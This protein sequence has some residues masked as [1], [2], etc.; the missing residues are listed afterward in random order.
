M[1]HAIEA[2]YDQVY[3]LPPCLEDWVGPEHAARFIRAFVAQAFANGLRLDWGSGTLQGKARYSER[4]L[5][6]IWLYGYFQ[7][8]R[9][10]RRLEAACKNDLGMIWLCGNHA[11]DHNTLWRFFKRNGKRIGEVYKHTVRIAAKAEL[12]GFVLHALDGTKVQA[13]V[14]N[15]SGLHRAALEKGIAELDAVIASLRASIEASQASNADSPSTDL[16]E[17]LR[18]K[19]RLQESVQLAFDELLASGTDHLNPHDPDARVMQCKDRNRNVFAYNNQAVVDEQSGLIV[20]QRTTQEPT[21]S[22][23][24]ATMVQQVEDDCGRAA[25]TTVADG[26][27]AASAPLADAHT[28]GHA[29]LVNLPSRLKPDPSDP[30]KTANFRFDP[31]QNA[32]LCPLGQTLDYTHTRWHKSKGEHLRAFRCHHTD[33]PLRAQCS[34]DPKGRKIELG[35]HYEALQAQRDAHE[36]PGAKQT[37]AKRRHIV[38]PAFAWIKEQLGLRRFTVRGLEGVQAQ[39]S[40]ACT[41][42]NLNRLYRDWKTGKLPLGPQPP[43]PETTKNQTHAAQTTQAKQTNSQHPLNPAP[44]R[45][46]N[47]LRRKNQSTRRSAPHDA[48]RL[49]FASAVA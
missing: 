11:P 28:A 22:H 16:P 40:L 6:S 8:I 32:V 44:W 30:L 12:V 17:R 19:T 21:D 10:L 31:E 23:L 15:R 1:G 41:T 43:K 14:A 3:M 18:E 42:Y 45:L 38:E 13:Q 24:L 37:L 34:N 39:W 46:T 5:L 7:R 27:Y 4:M 33:C 35:E 47:L 29:V 36:A 48:P 26:G 25:E 49:P 2:D 9:S 20:T